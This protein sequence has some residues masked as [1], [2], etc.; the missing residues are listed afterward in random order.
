[1]RGQE[2]YLNI[3]LNVLFIRLYLLCSRLGSKKMEAIRHMIQLSLVPFDII[4]WFWHAIAPDALVP[5]YK[6][7]GKV[8]LVTGA[9]TVLYM[10]SIL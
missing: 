10:C 9:G 4:R 8:A 2:H 7:R 6:L 1:M 5:T 3:V